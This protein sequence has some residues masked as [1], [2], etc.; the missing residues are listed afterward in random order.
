LSLGGGNVGFPARNLSHSIAPIAKK[1]PPQIMPSEPAVA[2][3]A[4]ALK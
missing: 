2:C 4:S 1:H 3:F